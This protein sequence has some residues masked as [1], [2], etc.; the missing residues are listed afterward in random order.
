MFVHAA[1]CCNGLDVLHS[2]SGPP[3]PTHT[4]TTRLIC[5]KIRGRAVHLVWVLRGLL[6]VG[7]LAVHAAHAL[8]GGNLVTSAATCSNSSSSRLYNIA[9]TTLVDVGSGYTLAVSA[10]A[11]LQLR[12]QLEVMHAV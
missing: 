11:S 4:T 1:P 10:T 12:K 6:L 5:K 2:E 7:G 8:P 9:S 3:K